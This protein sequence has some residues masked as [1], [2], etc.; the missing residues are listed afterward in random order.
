MNFRFLTVM[1]FIIILTCC[2]QRKNESGDSENV[3]TELEAG[4]PEVGWNMKNRVEIRLG[5]GAYLM[6]IANKI[7]VPILVYTS[8]VHDSE[9]LILKF[10][11]YTKYFIN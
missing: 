10:Y 1:L 8:P 5:E 4:M 2:G 3:E 7:T 9:N 11:L 6:D